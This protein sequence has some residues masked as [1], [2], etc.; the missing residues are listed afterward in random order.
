MTRKQIERIQNKIVKIK[1]A[2]LL[3]TKLKRRTH[4]RNF[5]F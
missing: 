1:R 5:S 3:I 4:Q 2:L